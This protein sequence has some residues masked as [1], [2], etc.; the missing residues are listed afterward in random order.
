MERNFSFTYAVARIRY[1]ENDLLPISFLYRLIG[2]PSISEIRKILGETVYGLK[3]EEDFDVMWENELRRTQGIVREV[4]PDKRLKSFFSYPYDIFNLKV[5]LKNKLLAKRGMKKN[6]D[7]LVDMGTVPVDRMISIVENEQYVYLPF[8]RKDSVFVLFDLLERMEK[9]ELD[10]KFIDLFLDKLYFHF[11]LDEAKALG[12]P[13]LVEYIRTLI[14]LTNIMSFFRSRFAERP[15]SFL[16]DVLIPGGFVDKDKLVD[17]Y[18]D[19]L[20][21]FVKSLRYSRYGDMVEKMSAIFESSKDL[22]SLEKLRDNYLI[23]NM[24]RYKYVMF[25]I[26]PIVAF[27]VAKEMEVKNLRIIITGKRAGL[28]EEILKERLRYAYV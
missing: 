1:L 14:D 5:L 19:S 3:E 8:Y 23:E 21:V 26:Q 17:L 12:E 27:A 16:N 6:W 15:K 25:G 13:F 7:V 10:T 18:Q 9:A 24:K 4:L 22:A 2:A 11:M 28:P 20:D